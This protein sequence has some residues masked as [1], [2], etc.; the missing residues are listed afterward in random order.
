MK[1][2]PMTGEV[3]TILN[4]RGAVNHM[5]VDFSNLEL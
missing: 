4:G 5:S 2:K 3:E 1:E